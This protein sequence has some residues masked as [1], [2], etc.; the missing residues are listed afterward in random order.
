MKCAHFEDMQKT[1][2]S[3]VKGYCKNY[4]SSKKLHA[5]FENKQN[6]FCLV[7]HF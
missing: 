6:N 1:L 2:K 5:K 3:V 7:I 4:R